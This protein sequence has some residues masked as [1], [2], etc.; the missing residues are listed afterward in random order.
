LLIVS[1]LLATPFARQQSP[2]VFR[3]GVDILTLDASVLDARGTPVSDLQAADFTV[4]IGGRPRKVVSA[5]FY[6]AVPEADRGRT[7]AAGAAI[8]SSYLGGDGPG[9]LVLFVVD[10]E[11]IQSGNGRALLEGAGAVLDALGPADAA[12]LRG[13]PVGVVAPTREHERVRVGLREMTGM[14]PPQGWRWHVTWDE[15]LAIDRGDTA[16]L[17]QVTYRECRPATV[18]EGVRT[19]VENCD[20]GVAAQAMEMVMLGRTKTQ[21]TLATLGNILNGLA[22]VKGP[23]H[24]VLISGGL[25]FEPG[26][27]TEY[28]RFARE[29]A[30]AGVVVHAIHVDQPA[31]DSSTSRR[32]VTSPD[33][34]RELSQGLTTL[35]G[36][37]GGAFYSGIGGAEGS[38]E[39]I[40][41]EITNIYQ[42]AVET[43]PTDGDGKERD[44]RV[45]VNR[46]DVKVRVPAA[47]V[48]PSPSES[49]GAADQLG[50]LLQQPT[51]LGGL[52]IKVA[53]FTTRGDDPE[54]LRVVIG[55]EVATGQRGTAGEW[56][57]TVLNNGNAVATGRRKLDAM[58]DEPWSITASVKLLPGRYRLR[59][60]ALVSD[61]RSGA[62]DVPLT[63]GLRVAGDLQLSDLVVGTAEG[64]RLVPRSRI[65][66]TSDVRAMIELMCADHARLAKARTLLEIVPAGSAEPVKRFMMGI[67]SGAADTILLGEATV[68]AGTLAPGR[69][70]A[71]AIVFA[72]D[73]PLGRVSRLFEVIP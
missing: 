3:T 13:L 61:G 16:A 25:L 35:A 72:D 64:G 52:P 1:L 53:S 17:N 48:F 28:A 42:I 26:L 32:V 62:V 36:M 11:S 50:Q 66:E 8:P 22:A 56:A 37:T 23:R 40:A 65:T 12:A 6:G 46:P 21:S 5:R 10:R 67:R 9:R 24:V 33:G 51:D 45:A 7:S 68:D 34:G 39:R 44:I 41:S 43:T 60:A 18:D 15:A 70:T 2:P 55:A 47:I 71:N 19:V 49:A 59:F 20:K 38:F 31:F 58:A 69:Y 57:F 63:A 14:M 73:Q 27:L 54:L 30:M 4:T 29:A